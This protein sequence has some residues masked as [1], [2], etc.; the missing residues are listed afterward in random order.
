[1]SDLYAYCRRD[2]QHFHH[3]YGYTILA[4]FCSMLVLRLS[5]FD[6]TVNGALFENGQ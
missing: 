6:L 5:I 1:M 3:F 2:I 4:A